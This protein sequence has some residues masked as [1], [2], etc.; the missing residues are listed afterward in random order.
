MKSPPLPATFNEAKNG[1]NK[2]YN[3]VMT[4]SIAGLKPRSVE[5][6]G[7]IVNIPPPGIVKTVNFINTKYT[8]KI[9]NSV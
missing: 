8:K 1:S 5:R 4:E 6:S 7:N 2:K 9:V 3:V